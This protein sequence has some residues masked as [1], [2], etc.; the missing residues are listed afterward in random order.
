LWGLD[1]SRWWVLK[2]ARQQRWTVREAF[3]RDGAN[4]CTGERRRLRNGLGG[5]GRCDISAYIGKIRTGLSLLRGPTI[6]S[7]PFSCAWRQLPRRGFRPVERAALRHQRCRRVGNYSAWH[8]IRGGPATLPSDTGWR[9]RTERTSAQI[10]TPQ[11]S[12]R[13]SGRTTWSARCS[14]V[15][16]CCIGSGTTRS[17]VG[18]SEVTGPATT[19]PKY[20]WQPRGTSGR[21]LTGPRTTPGWVAP[22]GGLMMFQRQPTLASLLP[23]LDQLIDLSRVLEAQ[24]GS[25]TYFLFY[26][27]GG[28]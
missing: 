15:T 9:S 19:V 22:L 25:P 17:L 8:S 4:R 11:S 24:H 12:I 21:A 13:V 26:R 27:Y 6:R 5:G 28:M 23:L 2:N 16:A 10:S 3:A 20:T 7:G 14:L 1:R 18:W